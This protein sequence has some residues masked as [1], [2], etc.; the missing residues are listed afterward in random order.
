MVACHCPD[1]KQTD[2]PLHQDPSFQG[3]DQPNRRS[4]IHPCVGMNAKCPWIQN[5]IDLGFRIP[6]PEQ[7]QA[8]IAPVDRQ[9]PASLGENQS[10]W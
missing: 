7:S 8:L 9:T 6:L 4:A 2:P 1:A 3:I 10:L 5:A